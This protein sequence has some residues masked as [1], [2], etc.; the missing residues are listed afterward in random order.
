MPKQ[1]RLE[2]LVLFSSS[3]DVAADHLQTHLR[4]SDFQS[5]IRDLAV[6]KLL[7]SPETRTRDAKYDAGV[8][9]VTVVDEK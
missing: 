6:E 4:Q 9:R 1:F 5:R 7:A 3:Q 8:S 2:I